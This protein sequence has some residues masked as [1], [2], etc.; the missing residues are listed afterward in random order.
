MKA[1]AYTYMRKQYGIEPQKDWYVAKRIA[2]TPQQLEQR[3]GHDRFRYAQHVGDMPYRHAEPSHVV[4]L[5]CEVG[6]QRWFAPVAADPQLADLALEAFAFFGLER[7]HVLPRRLVDVGLEVLFDDID[8]HPRLQRLAL[9]RE[10]LVA[11]EAGVP[12]ALVLGGL[13]AAEQAGVDVEVNLAV[14]QD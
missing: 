6:R 3:P 13:D 5:P 1:F 11:V 7:E 8:E 12:L 4:D 14:S 2:I 10:R 9:A